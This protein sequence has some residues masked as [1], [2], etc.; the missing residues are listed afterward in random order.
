LGIEW[1]ESSVKDAQANAELNNVKNC[2][3]I[4]LD[5]KALQSIESECALFGAPDVVITD[6]PRAGMHPKAIEILREWAP[7]I[8]IY[9][10]CNPASLARDSALLCENQQYRLINCTPVDLFPQTNHVESIARFERL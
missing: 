6:P 7:P 2:Q 10:S 4:Q 9:V 1:V 8:I 5:M 3:F